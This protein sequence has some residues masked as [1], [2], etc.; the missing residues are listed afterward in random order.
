MITG[1]KNFAIEFRNA[2]AMHATALLGL[3]PKTN[4]KES[5]RSNFIA[6]LPFLPISVLYDFSQF[7]LKNLGGQGAPGSASGDDE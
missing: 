2:T 5:C 6:L 3:Y 1:C 4:K 7:V